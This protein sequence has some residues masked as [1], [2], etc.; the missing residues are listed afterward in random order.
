[1]KQGVVVTPEGHVTVLEL[2]GTL[3]ELQVTVGGYIECVH[4]ASRPDLSVFVNA[5][6]KYVSETNIKATRWAL[7]DLFQGD[8]LAGT[9]IVLGSVDQTGETTGLTP[10]QVEEVVAALG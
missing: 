2:K 1:M 5:E 10:K 4:L 9:V 7:R 8:Y 6:G 3:E